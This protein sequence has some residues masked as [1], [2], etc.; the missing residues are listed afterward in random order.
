M[1]RRPPRST[2]FPYTT[3]FR[4]GRITF[5]RRL[6]LVS[7]ARRVDLGAGDQALRRDAGPGIEEDLDRARPVV[8]IDLEAKRAV[9]DERTQHRSVETQQAPLRPLPD[10][11]RRARAGPDG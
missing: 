9:V 8:D 3:L 5:V 7:E 1:I 11:S 6:E 2:L 4:S 10:R